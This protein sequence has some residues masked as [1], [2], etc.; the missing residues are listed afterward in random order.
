MI[1]KKSQFPWT[2]S[3]GLLIDSFEDG[4]TGQ[5]INYVNARELEAVL[6]SATTIYSA[7]SAAWGL[8]SDNNTQVCGKVV[9]VESVDADTV[10]FLLDEVTRKLHALGADDAE[11]QDLIA[12]ANSILG[13]V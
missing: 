8:V 4:D 13:K 2:S 11:S 9:A 1:K 10:E 12:R 6:E 7:D 5:V 3:L